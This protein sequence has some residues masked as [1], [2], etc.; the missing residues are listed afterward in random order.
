MSPID[1]GN[2]SNTDTIQLFRF[3]CKTKILYFGI[4]KWCKNCKKKLELRNDQKITTAKITCREQY[5]GL[6]QSLKTQMLEYAN[7]YTTNVGC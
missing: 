6:L 5:Y 2:Y 1:T 7:H 3:K 4:K